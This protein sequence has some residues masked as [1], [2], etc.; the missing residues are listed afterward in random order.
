MLRK[1]WS[2]GLGIDLP[3]SLSFDP[4]VPFVICKVSFELP[5]VEGDIVS[6]QDKTEVHCACHIRLKLGFYE[7]HL[8]G[9]D[10]D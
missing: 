6:F 5:F 2:E 9:T 1:S 4:P 3:C 10:F 7:F 8:R